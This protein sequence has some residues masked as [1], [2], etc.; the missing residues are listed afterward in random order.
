[1]NYSLLC[2]DGSIPVIHCFAN[3]I[4]LINHVLHTHIQCTLIELITR[5][6]LVTVVAV[7]TNV[8]LA[9]VVVVTVPVPIFAV[10]P[11][12][13]LLLPFLVDC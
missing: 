2:L 4:V 6:S 12:P 13:F 5:N 1:M 10:F 9:I 11:P 3:T 8:I 7:A